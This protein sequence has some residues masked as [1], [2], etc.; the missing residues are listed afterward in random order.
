VVEKILYKS[1][2]ILRRIGYRI[3][4]Y[5]NISYSKRI[6]ELYE[7]FDYLIST[8]KL[9]GVFCECGYGY[10]TSFTVLSHFAKKLNKKIYGIDSF[11]GFP[12]ISKVDHS[13]RNPIKGDWAVRTL[14]EANNYVRNSGLF[15]NDEQYKLISLAF[16]EG[17]KNPI[18][19]EKIS[20]LHIDLDLY[21]GYKYALELF[22]DQVESG[23]IVVFDEYKQVKWPGATL[24]IN[25]F[26]ASKN[27]SLDSIGQIK[28]KFFIVKV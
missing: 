18:P 23:G 24:A 26:L 28:D 9:K 25:E 20:L 17:V 19:H 8:K 14:S 21:D 27:L 13:L 10:G 11:G 2:F 5:E 6:L 3:E 7:I 15:E 16:K 22:W 4:K 1:V 12:Q